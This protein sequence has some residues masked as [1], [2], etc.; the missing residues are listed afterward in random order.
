MPPTNRLLY[1][2]GHGNEAYAMNLS[3]ACGEA[4]TSA[5]SAMTDVLT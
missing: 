2:Y 5:L 4:P 3:I 1:A